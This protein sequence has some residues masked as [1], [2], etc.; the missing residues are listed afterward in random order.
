MVSKAKLFKCFKWSE[1]PLMSQ[2]LPFCRR[3]EF[4]GG[5][6]SLRRRGGRRWWGRRLRWIWP[7]LN[8]GRSPVV[9]L[10]VILQSWFFLLLGL[11]VAFLNFLWRRCAA[12]ALQLR[13]CFE[14]WH[15]HRRKKLAV[16]AKPRLKPRT[17]KC[18]GKGKARFRV[19]KT[20]WQSKQNDSSYKT[21]I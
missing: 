19:M 15:S 4:R 12:P 6:F 14:N 13:I 10:H 8:I 3:R 9:S 2:S 1:N 17:R 20:G 7:L 5:V 21:K 16:F 11:L 18:V